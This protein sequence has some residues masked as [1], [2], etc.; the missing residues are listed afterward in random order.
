MLNG[1]GRSINNDFKNYIKHLWDILCHNLSV[2]LEQPCC[3]GEAMKKM[4]QGT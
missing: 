4:K 1:S 2:R 3:N